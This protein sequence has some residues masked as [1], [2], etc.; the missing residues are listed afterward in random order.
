MS[1]EKQTKTAFKWTPFR[2]IFLVV[3]LAGLTLFIL[4]YILFKETDYN[5][6]LLIVGIVVMIV[7]LFFVL[8]GKPSFS[9]PL[10]RQLSAIDRYHVE[11]K[12][13]PSLSLLKSRLSVLENEENLLF[14]RIEKDN[15]HFVEYTY[16]LIENKEDSKED[17]KV[18]ALIEKRF[19]KAKA[20][21]KTEVMNYLYFVKD[22][23]EAKKQLE[24]FAAVLITGSHDKTKE[25]MIPFLISKETN[26][27][28]YYLPNEEDKTSYYQ[29]GI[30]KAILVLDLHEIG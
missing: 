28:F 1:E 22:D 16:A 6:P 26:N 2:I 3:F 12:K 5:I 30:D 20:V 10:K 29:K 15:D 18:L 4:N 23:E 25:E 14:F 19:D 8:Y 11:S 24:S 13:G 21:K 9:S 17:D 7:G 27:Y